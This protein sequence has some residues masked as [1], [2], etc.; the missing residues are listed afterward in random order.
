MRIT[1]RQLKRIIRETLLRETEEQYAYSSGVTRPWKA[2][3][4]SS[5]E[6]AGHGVDIS[7]MMRNKSAI[8]DWVDLLIDELEPTLPQLRNL[9]EKHYATTIK[10]ITDSVFRALA[11]ALK[12]F[13]PPPAP[14][15]RR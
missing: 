3:M 12:S 7:A 6:A 14:S 8:A 1:K 13:S 10:R 5:T 2:D 15:P 11:D 4:G 9:P